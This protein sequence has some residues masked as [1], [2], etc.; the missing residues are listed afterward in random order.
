MYGI[1]K[2]KKGCGI[3]VMRCIDGKIQCTLVTG[4]DKIHKELIEEIMGI[5][6]MQGLFQSINTDKKAVEYLWLGSA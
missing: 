2:K 3:L 1:R 6:E 5:S 4:K